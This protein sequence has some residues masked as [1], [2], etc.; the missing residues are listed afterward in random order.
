MEVYM[1]L[2]GIIGLSDST[3]NNLLFPGQQAPDSQ[4]PDFTQGNQVTVPAGYQPI[5]GTDDTKTTPTIASSAQP[6]SGFNVQQFAS[7]PRGYLIGQGIKGVQSLF[8][9]NKTPTQSP[10]QQAA[11]TD[12]SVAE[13]MDTGSQL[14]SLFSL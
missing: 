6:S 5:A 8:G 1:G 7:N 9:S 3:N 12:A 2:G 4:A 13:G 14:G 11:A 10:D